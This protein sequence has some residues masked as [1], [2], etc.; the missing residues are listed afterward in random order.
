M[1]GSERRGQRG[2]QTGQRG[3]ATGLPAL[4]TGTACVWQRPT[5]LEQ[6][7]ALHLTSRR[8]RLRAGDL[9]RVKATRPQRNAPPPTPARGSGGTPEASAKSS[10]GAKPTLRAN[11]GGFCPPCQS[12]NRKELARKRGCENGS[13]RSV[14][15][16]RRGQRASDSPESRGVQ[17][18]R[19]SMTALTVGCQPVSLGGIGQLGRPGKVTPAVG[20]QP[21]RKLREEER[22]GAQ[23]PWR[24]PR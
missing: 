21:P 4:A 15:G 13:H 14:R 8:R 17:S 5:H 7:F 2:P 19:F 10:V 6:H 9:A 3:R 23:R 1:A 12:K 20:S 16:V 11:H 18:Q 24:A 22:A